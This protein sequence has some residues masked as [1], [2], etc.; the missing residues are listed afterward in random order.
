MKNGRQLCSFLLAYSILNHDICLLSRKKCEVNKQTNK[1]IN[2]PE[3]TIFVSL[4][5]ELFLI[6]DYD[7]FQ[8]VTI[9]IM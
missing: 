9:I 5:M 6:L 7:S 4:R 8:P 1:G 3:T 2:N